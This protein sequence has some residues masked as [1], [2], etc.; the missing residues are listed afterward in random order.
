MNTPTIVRACL[1]ACI[2]VS[3]ATA[4]TR[5][6]GPWWP[7][8]EW[9]AEDQAGASNRITPEKILAALRIVQTG[10]VYE[11]GQV[12]EASMPLVGTR[13]YGMKL[14][15]TGNPLGTNNVVYNDEMLSTEIGQVGTQFDGLGHVGTALSYADGS[16]QLVF[17]NGFTSQEIDDKAGLRRLGIEHV[18]PILTRGVLIDVPAYKG[19]ERLEGGYE[20][21]LDDV[22]GALARQGIDEDSIAPGDAI[23]FRY[24]W[25]QLWDDHQTYGGAQPGIGFEVSDWL[26]EKQITVTGSDTTV[27]EVNPNPEA[28]LAI[29]IHQELMTKNGIFNIENMTFEELAADEVYEFL[30]IATPIRFAGATGSPLRPLAIR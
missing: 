7:H 10:Q 27:T 22:R 11:I 4:Q 8:A 14:L 12:Y 28:G 6:S 21:T 15:S 23:L 25:A 19:V 30:L 5:A 9:G 2:A 24:G 13:T 29:P 17:Y 26:I 18:K 3:S 16:R 20:V 1:L